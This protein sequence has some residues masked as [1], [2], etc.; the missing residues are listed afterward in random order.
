MENDIPYSYHGTHISISK[1]M[2]IRLQETY[3]QDLYPLQRLKTLGVTAV[4]SARTASA[5]F[6]A[7]VEKNSKKAVKHK[8]DN[9]S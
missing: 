3:P 8:K 5:S 2:K 9:E 6:T 7:E 1:V 4:R